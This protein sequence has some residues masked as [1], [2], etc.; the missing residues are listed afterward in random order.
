MFAP[1]LG[2]R[3]RQKGIEDARMIIA[4]DVTADDGFVAVFQDSFSRAGL[5]LGP[6]IRALGCPT[7]LKFDDRIKLAI[8]EV[9]FFNFMTEVRHLF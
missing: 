3:H 5:F 1:P 7:I 2:H 9:G 8:S 4:D 6:M